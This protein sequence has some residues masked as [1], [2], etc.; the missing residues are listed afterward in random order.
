MGTQNIQ[1]KGLT[2]GACVKLAQKR[3]QRLPQVRQV[4]V[5]IDGQATLVVDRDIPRNEI[6]QILVGT[7]YQLA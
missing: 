2:C 1:L 3:L 5:Y 7:P 4:S 6:I